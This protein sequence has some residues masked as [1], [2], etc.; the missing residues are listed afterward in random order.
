MLNNNF[1]CS[2]FKTT[3]NFRESIPTIMAIKEFR[4]N[5]LSKCTNTNN[6]YVG[7]L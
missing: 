3:V 4:K 6:N 7:C 5:N 1:A 2:L